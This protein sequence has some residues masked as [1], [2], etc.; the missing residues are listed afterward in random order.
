MG[1]KVQGKDKVHR[2]A[3]KI[4]KTAAIGKAGSD[5]ADDVNPRCLNKFRYLSDTYA[6]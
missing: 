6:K 4:A 1:I 2:H 3:G 5:G